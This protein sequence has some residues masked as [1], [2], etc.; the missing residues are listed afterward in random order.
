M[1]TVLLA[2]EFQEL[3][4]LQSS[5]EQKEANSTLLQDR[6]KQLTDALHAARGETEA[7][8]K[9]FT[10]LAE[11]EAKIHPNKQTGDAIGSRCSSSSGSNKS[12]TGGDARE[13]NVKMIHAFL[14]VRAASGYVT[15]PEIITVMSEVSQATENELMILRN[16]EK[17][18]NQIRNR[19]QERIDGLERQRASDGTRI[20]SLRAERNQSE[21]TFSNIVHAALALSV[22]KPVIKGH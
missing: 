15:T 2:S 22:R 1:W 5:L 14:Q 6:V 13:E 8:A 11:T 10:L 17:E 18:F 21:S 7:I 12:F 9:K 19:L 4:K 20:D 3:Q 16:T